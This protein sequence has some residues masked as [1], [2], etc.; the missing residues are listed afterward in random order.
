MWRDLIRGHWGLFLFLCLHAL[1][2][3]TWIAS[4]GYFTSGD[5]RV[6][7]EHTITT[8]LSQ[9]GSVYDFAVGLG[10]AQILGAYKLI[11]LAHGLIAALG[12]KYDISVR[13]L[14][15]WPFLLLAP[16]CLYILLRS[17]RVSE[18]ATLVGMCIYFLNTYVLVLQQGHLLVLLAYGLAPLALWSLVRYGC[19][20][21]AAG[22]IAAA[23]ATVPST[24]YDARIGYVLC[25]IALVAILVVNGRRRCN[26]A[27]AHAGAF[28]ICV[29]GLN[30]FWILPSFGAA[31]ESASRILER[32][33]FGSA[34]FTLQGAIA[35]FHPFWTGAAPAAFEL[36]SVKW[37]EFAIPVL[38]VIG[39]LLSR[40][41]PITLAF[42][43]LALAGITLAKQ[44]AP[45][46]G[47]LYV[48][49]FT[50][51]PGF[52]AFREA[53][54]FLLLVALG[55]AV[56]CAFGVD[57]LLRTPRYKTAAFA[58][59]ALVIAIE[60]IHSRPLLDGSFGGL[61]SPHKEPSTYVALNERL[62][63]ER[64]LFRVLWVPNT[65]RWADFT[66]EHPSIGAVDAIEGDWSDA[67]RDQF[68]TSGSAL[69]RLIDSNTPTFNGLL[70]AAAVRY[71]AVPI[72]SGL[73]R[74]LFIWYGNRAR[75]LDA[76]D[77]D[78]GLVRE[79]VVGN[80][81]LYRVKQPMG[82][83]RWLDQ[84]GVDQAGEISVGGRGIESNVQLF[85]RK[86]Q[87][88]VRLS[89]STTYDAGWA[90]CFLPSQ[91]QCRRSEIIDISGLALNSFDVKAI[92]AGA[93]RW[94]LIYKPANFF[95]TG[96]AISFIT[97][98]LCAGAIWTSRRS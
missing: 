84:D 52:S 17:L 16:L 96:I 73:D 11:E 25:A 35:L 34:F 20:P 66:P 42:F 15:L 4:G 37:Y 68:G 32:P 75:F 8:L 10:G 65:P 47:S 12:F 90:L 79:R 40:R 14:F 74:Q 38:A 19:E 97:L 3:W 44:I 57:A 26:Q 92:P 7:P 55:Y 62:Y 77:R 72:D 95:R 86:P 49:L 27:F 67:V 41:S 30:A 5:A 91:E 23:V 81:A 59:V 21:T 51:L 39:T 9:S 98:I 6:Y 46:F 88:A 69:L 28:A 83:F 45:P 78:D 48:F 93:F 71:V 70:A 18:T 87:S 43:A 53:S 94:G 82:I 58:L 29:M 33:L 80:V 50:Y 24:L 60:V 36:Q 64:G 89:F 2:H 63:R 31:T 54:K 76:L 13:V 56:L 85:G 22:A 1:V 61:A